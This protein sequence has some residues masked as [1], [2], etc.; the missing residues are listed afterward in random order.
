MLYYNALTQF[1]KN[2]SSYN[3]KHYTKNIVKVTI[4]SKHNDS[5]MHFYGQYSYVLC[6]DVRGY[7]IYL[8]HCHYFFFLYV[9]SS[10]Y[11]TELIL[12]IINVNN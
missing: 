2:I 4:I 9:I 8:A 12:K 5:I 3:T 6:K 1:I 7:W 10:C 11:M